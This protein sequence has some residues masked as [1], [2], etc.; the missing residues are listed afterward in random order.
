M[1]EQMPLDLS[2]SRAARDEG[3]R[4]AVDHAEDVTP[5]WADLAYA[6]IV[7]YFSRYEEATSEQVRAAAFGIVPEPPDKRAWGGPFARAARA[8]V[9]VRDRYTTARDPKVHC[10]IMTVWR[11]LTVLP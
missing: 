6:F 8:G 3:I 10:S 2:A 9:I 5:H 11:S 1:I 4:R 7:D